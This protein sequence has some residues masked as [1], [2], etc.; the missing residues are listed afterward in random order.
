M[1]TEKKKPPKPPV[2]PVIPQPTKRVKV[3]KA[4][5]EEL[6]DKRPNK[7]ERRL[8]GLRAASGLTI[9]QE[10]FAAARATGM[11][12]SEAIKAIGFG[13]MSPV[14]GNNWDKIPKVQKRIVELREIATQNAIL[15]TGLSREWVISRLMT[16]VDRCMQTEPVRDNRGKVIPGQFQFDAKGANGALKMLGDTLSMFRQDVKAPPGRELDS[17]SDEDVTRLTLELAKQVGLPLGDAQTI[18]Y[19]DV[20]GHESDRS[21]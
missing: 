6:L 10:A 11:S 20:V 19:T 2:E 16:I 7:Q 9:Q 14:T 18:E 21:A 8:I 17:L 4:H 5:T 15:S 12:P 3:P 1:P 13:E